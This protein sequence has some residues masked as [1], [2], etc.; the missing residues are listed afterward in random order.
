MIY[1][2]HRND[3]LIYRKC[4][5]RV[6][7]RD[8]GREGNDQVRALRGVNG[9]GAGCWEVVRSVREQG[10]SDQGRDGEEGGDPEAATREPDGAHQPGAVPSGIGGQVGAEAPCSR[11]EGTRMHTGSILQD[12]QGCERGDIAAEQRKAATRPAGSPGKVS[13]GCGVGPGVRRVQERQYP[14]SGAQRERDAD[15]DRSGDCGGGQKVAPLAGSSGFIWY[16]GYLSGVF[17]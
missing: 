3:T 6:N 8:T 10:M 2:T 17:H 14:E 1:R 7:G 5:L 11:G 9:R 4:R 16:S 12:H 13:R 15:R